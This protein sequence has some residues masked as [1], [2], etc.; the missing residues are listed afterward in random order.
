MIKNV[1]AEIPEKLPE[2]LF[3][4]IIS[5]PG[6]RIERILS[7]GHSSPENYW[8]DQD[9]NEWVMLLSGSAILRFAEGDIQ[10]EMKAGDYLN[11]P[12][13]VKHRVEETDPNNTSI[14]LAVFY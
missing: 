6:I 4:T 5:S 7:R 13:G 11:I 3:E 8:Y 9:E 14:W 1:F 10:V 12:A 2:E